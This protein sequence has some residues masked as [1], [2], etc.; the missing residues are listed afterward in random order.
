M[1]Q[2]ELFDAVELKEA[3]LLT[4]GRIAAVGTPGAI[5]EILDNG[6]AYMVEMFDSW[7]KTNGKRDLVPADP[8]AP[9]AFVETLGLEVVRPQQ[10]RLVKPAS[11][12]VGH[13]PQ[14]LMA[15]EELPDA[16][17][18][19]VVDFAEFLRQKQQRQTVVSERVL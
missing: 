15:L 4:D 19:E 18:A 12:T 8:E 9:Q 3:I 2:F 17:V 10:I 1:T 7:V 16:L 5:V 13:R 14:L 6:A 11:E